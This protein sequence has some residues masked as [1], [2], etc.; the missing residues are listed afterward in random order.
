MFEYVMLLDAPKLLLC[1]SGNSEAPLMP[2]TI[3]SSLPYTTCFSISL[4][5]PLSLTCCVCA[6]P[7]HTHA[8]QPLSS[9]PHPPTSAQPYHDVDVTHPLF[10]TL[11]YTSPHILTWLK[12]TPSCLR[13][14]PFHPRFA[15]QEQIA[16]IT[17]SFYVQTI[18]VQLH[19]SAGQHETTLH[20][21]LQWLQ[22]A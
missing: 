4:A 2:A 3:S 12:P 16:L 18:N 19:P 22:E 10:P 13:P 9:L 7:H 21:R 5:S 14:S 1:M 8:P 17:V 15:F 6:L 20:L 11:N